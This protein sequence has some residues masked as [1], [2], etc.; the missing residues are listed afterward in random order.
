MIDY[1][2]VLAFAALPTLANFTG[3]ILAELFDV[4]QR[5][6]NWALH[7]AAGIVIG[8]TAVEVMPLVLETDVQWLIIVAFVFGGGSTLRSIGA[9]NSC[10]A[11]SAERMILQHG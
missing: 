3:G 11:V 5:V 2:L 4:S 10:R 6:F 8:V 1:L 7:A 9:L